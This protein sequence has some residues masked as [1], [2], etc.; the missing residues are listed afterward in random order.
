MSLFDRLKPTPRWKHAD[1]QVRLASIPEIEST[2]DDAAEILA[3]VARADA[4][5]RVRRAAAQRLTNAAVLSE[6]LTQDSDEQ[7][8]QAAAD[9]LLQMACGNGQHAEA[10]VSA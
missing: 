7:V 3:T 9:V 5:P 8:R 10:A 4:D 6:V 2:R 1:P